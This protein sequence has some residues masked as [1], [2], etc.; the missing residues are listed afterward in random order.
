MYA[1][2]ANGG[3]M[4]QPHL[5]ESIQGQRR[6]A[7]HSRRILRPGVDAELVSMLKNVV[8]Y[9]SGTGVQARIPGYSVAGKTGT[10][11]KANGHGGYALGQYMASFVGFFP[12]EPPAGADHGGRGHAAREYL[13]RHG[14]RAGLREDRRL[15]RQASSASRR[16]RP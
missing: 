7:L 2:I 5:I 9:Q 16:T 14:G 4:P 8:D 3:V 6:P 1:A 15:V 11:Q 10:A 13:R 12:A